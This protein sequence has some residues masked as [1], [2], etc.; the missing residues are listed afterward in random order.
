MSLK[1]AVKLLA[2]SNG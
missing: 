2:R 1:S